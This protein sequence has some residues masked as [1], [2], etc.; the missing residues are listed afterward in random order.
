[1]CELKWQSCNNTSKHTNVKFWHCLLKN[2]L[3]QK[4]K[5]RK[6]NRQILPA[7]RFHGE[8]CHQKVTNSMAR[9]GIGSS[10]GCLELLRSKHLSHRVPASHELL[11]HQ[12]VHI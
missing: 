12:G 10:E 1:M 5:L 11:P 3:R 8:E 4:N 7:E 6:K 2:K 9:M